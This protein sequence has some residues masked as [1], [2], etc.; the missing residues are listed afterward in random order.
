[1]SSERS[2]TGSSHEQQPTQDPG[3]MAMVLS[4]ENID[5]ESQSEANSTTAEDPSPPGSELEPFNE[6]GSVESP[7]SPP[8][9]N[10]E[11]TGDSI[12][13]AID[14][15][16]M[17]ADPPTSA[18]PGLLEGEPDSTDAPEHQASVSNALD[19]IQRLNIDED[20][21]SNY[22]TDDE[23]DDGSS[24]DGMH[25]VP[26]PEAP[27]YDDDL[28]KALKEIKG[29]LSNI[30]ND[31]KQSPL[32]NDHRSDFSQQYEQVRALTQ[33]EC[34]ET[35]TVGFIGNSGVGKSRLINSLL[36]EEGLAHSVCWLF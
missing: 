29:H 10:R 3:A 36:G 35:R 8:S 14:G 24:L 27:I 19:G 11:A 33:L 31:M 15:L 12:N 18:S 16:T 9:V 25:Q 7:S 23:H 2:N 1:M 4:I 34:P 20:Q 28:D 26:L 6:G 30:E 32:I 5:D 21:E 17:V 22:S 13:D